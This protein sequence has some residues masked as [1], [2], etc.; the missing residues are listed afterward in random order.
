MNRFLQFCGVIA[1]VLMAVSC[2]GSSTLDN[3]VA[4]VFLTI[5]VEENDPDIDICFQFGDVSVEKMTVTSTLK[6]PGGTPSSNQ[7]VRLSRWVITPSRTD[8]GSTTS[9]E[10]SYDQAVYVPA[11]GSADLENY[12]VYPLEYLNDIPLANLWPENGGVDPETGNTNIRESLE[13]VI[14]GETVSG[15]S[16]ATQPVP[17]AFNFFCNGQ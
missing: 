7:D 11:D 8:G 15:K 12:R 16:V 6:D 2:G 3:T 17:I 1:L 14:Y 9:P 4:S 10:W 13:L 5:E